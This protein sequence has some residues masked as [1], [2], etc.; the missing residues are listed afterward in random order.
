MK[1][2]RVTK[3]SAV[4]LIEDNLLGDYNLSK[5]DLAASLRAM[6]GEH[7]DDTFVLFAYEGE[8]VKAFL[9]ALSEPEA[10]W[11]AL[12]QGWSTVPAKTWKSMF[13]RLCL[14]AE[15]KGKEFIRAE[16][17]RSMDV[18]LVDFGF[19]ELSK[20]MSFRVTEDDHVEIVDEMI[21]RNKGPDEVSET[22]RSSGTGEEKR[23]GNG[24]LR[25]DVHAASV[26]GAGKGHP[27]STPDTDSRKKT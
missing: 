20:V 4:S 8:E 15:A 1:I 23:D 9:I 14:W 21:R 11:V 24:R 5:E 27:A 7:P 18:F 25:T 19:Q 12:V 22:E 13:L 17:S 2:L 10:D 16:T 6:L 26:S 3:P